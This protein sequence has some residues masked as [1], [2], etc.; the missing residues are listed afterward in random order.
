M[1]GPRPFDPAE[2]GTDEATWLLDPRWEDVPSTSAADLVAPFEQVVVLAPHPDDESLGP[3]GVLAAA[4]AAGLAVHVVLACDGERSHPHGSYDPAAVAALRRDEV[5]AAVGHLGASV[6]LHRLGLPDGGLSQHVE[7]M[8]AAVAGL[9]GERLTLVLAPWR[10]DGHPDHHATADAACAVER[11]TGAQVALMPVW[12]WHWGTPDDL[13]WDQLELVDL[14]PVELAAKS[15]AIASHRSQVEPLGPGRGD[16]ALLGPHVRARFERVVETIIRTTPLPRV[17]HEDG[18][19]ER[20]AAFDAM[21]A[22]DDDPWHFGSWY[23]RRKRALTLAVLAQERYDRVLDL[24]CATGELTHGLAG[25]AGA[26]TA[27]DLSESALEMA[28]AR[29]PARS[30]PRVRWV[31]GECPDVLRE[32]VDEGFR[33]DLVVLSEIGY[34]LTGSELLSTLRSVLRL[35]ADGG[36]LVLVHWRHPTQDI[37]LDGEAV[38]AQVRAVLG[39]PRVA[40][41]DADVLLDVYGGQVR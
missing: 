17:P 33:H 2:P 4:S 27:V 7:A 22:A 12:L 18:S 26:I 35:R 6:R 38:H 31:Q 34:F 3:G 25:R 13:P 40:Y 21:Y 29:P 24:G 1:S 19:W 37:P 20:G 10:E 8:T 15:A 39:E 41:R 11:A 9:V 16:E 28:R 36:E 14:G 23:E 32:L 30:S 5:A